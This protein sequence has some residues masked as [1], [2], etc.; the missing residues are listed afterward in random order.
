[1]WSGVPVV[2]SGGDVDGRETGAKEGMATGAGKE[3]GRLLWI[4]LGVCGR[5]EAE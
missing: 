4:E 3:M 1:M 5:E 2:K